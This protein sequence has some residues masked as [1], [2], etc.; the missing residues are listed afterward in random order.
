MPAHAQAASQEQPF[1]GLRPFGFADHDYFFGRQDQTFSLYR[2]ADR[3]RFVAV[4]GSSGSGKSSLVRAGLLPLIAEEKTQADVPRWRSVEMRPGSAPLTALAQALASLAKDDDEAIAEARRAPIDFYLRQ[5][6]FGIE[7]ALSAIPALAETPILIV[8]DQFEEL[9]R[10]GGIDG[11]RN[12]AAGDETLT[13]EDATRF[14]QLLLEASRSSRCNA[15]ILLTMRSDFIGECARFKG[16]PEAV[17]ASQFLVPSLTRDQLTE[18]VERPI[19]KAGATIEPALVQR[20]LNDSSAYDLDQ[21]PV[22]QHCLLR[23]WEKA[24]EDTAVQNRHSSTTAGGQ[25][26][27]PGRRLTE[28]QYEAIGRMARAL[29]RHADKILS[30]AG[31]E[32]IVEKVFRALFEIDTQGRAVRRAISFDQLWEETGEPEPEIRRIVDRFR[33]DDCSFL[34]PSKSAVPELTSKTQI[35]VGHEA[36]LRRWTRISGEPGAV[37][38]EQ[39]ADLF[40]HPR[41][42]TGKLSRALLR[43]PVT[44]DVK[45]R[46]KQPPPFRG[47]LQ[48]EAE[49]AEIYRGLLTWT[50]NRRTALQWRTAKDHQRWWDKRRPT[51]AWAKRYGGGFKDVQGLIRRSVTRS[52]LLIALCIVSP[53]LALSG[54]A[55]LYAFYSGYSKERALRAN[56]QQIRLDSAQT[57]VDRVAKS[58]QKGDMGISGASDMLDVAHSL[59]VNLIQE[60]GSTTQTTVSIASLNL[61][62]SDIAATVDDPTQARKYAKSARDLITP[63]QAA[64]PRNLKLLE[65]LCDSIWRMADALAGSDTAPMTQQNALQ[66]YKAAKKIARQLMDIEP[67]ESRWPRKLVFVMQKIGD[68]SQVVG[69]WHEAVDEYRA[70]LKIIKRV[71]E[72]PPAHPEARRDLA[73]TYSRLGQALSG[74]GT[75]E[76]AKQEFQA[77]L[78]IRK[79]LIKEDHLNDVLQ[80]NLADSYYEFARLYAKRGDD[81]NLV[82]K[83]YDGAID[84]RKTLNTKDPNNVEWQKRLAPLYAGKAGILKQKGDLEG[85]LDAYRLAY[86]LR[87]Q[88]SL[89]DSRNPVL[90]RNYAGAG[91]A[92]AD[93]LVLQKQNLG[94]ALTLHRN[95]I[96]TLDEFRPRYDTSVFQSYEEIGDILRYQ[97]DLE[98]ALTEYKRAQG[99]AEDSADKEPASVAW[100]KNLESSYAKIGEFLIEQGRMSDALSHYKKALEFVEA[101][102]P[103]TWTALAQALKSQ[104]EELSAK[105]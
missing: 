64:E 102:Q 54:G 93:V 67:A 2:L 86:G 48:L 55:A 68:V 94:E 73:N 19:A 104:I 7:K 71:V 50:R 91:M 41:W 88:L 69:N 5:S 33:E 84:I 36:L 31:P 37:A 28:Q 85:A 79:E 47:W 16:L 59:I 22:L 32:N 46:S 56:G 21:L 53:I 35:D 6:S 15:H 42:I 60:E 98:S 90:A 52:N 80:S 25:S 14:A 87:R 70:A 18:V 4:V 65:V 77:S 9:F 27:G 11:L 45:Q 39:S 75:L 97:G 72:G 3:T 8:V 51:E 23:L 26:N 57:L 99:I 12:A 29:S 92:V 105:L 101:K 43:R 20:L 63:L 44:I 49:D 78:D 1:P 34:T 62:F 83:E 58:V 66:E 81:L 95:A 38:I 17:S 10:Y 40:A 30:Q 24:G 74:Q 13:K 76:A 96:E 82:V 103:Q 61:T 100:Q 89:R